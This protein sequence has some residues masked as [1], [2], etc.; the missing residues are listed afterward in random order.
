MY[1]GAGQV[2][3]ILQWPCHCFHSYRAAAR[4]YIDSHVSISNVVPNFLFLFPTRRM[5]SP[6]MAE[7]PASFVNQTRACASAGVCVCARTR[8][9][10]TLVAV[11]QVKANCCDYVAVIE[12]GRCV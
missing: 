3:L 7:A 10:V 11:R 4:L 12:Q 8:A 6:T 5:L 2:E 1:P 9:R